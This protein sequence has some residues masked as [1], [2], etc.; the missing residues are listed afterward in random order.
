MLYRVAAEG[1]LLLHLSFIGFV[2]FG[3]L[4]TARWRWIPAIHLPSAAWG[5]FVELSG[6]V[7][8]LT[9]AE[10]YLWR[11][12]G[13][14]AYSQDFIQHYLVPVIYPVGLTQRIQ[15]ILAVVVIVTNALV[16]GWVLT[17]RRATHP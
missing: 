10:N 4:L 15:L 11:R 9:Y 14:A 5:C 13:R 3:A 12:A 7:C 16:Y 6:R 17:R 8:P 1:V 2:L